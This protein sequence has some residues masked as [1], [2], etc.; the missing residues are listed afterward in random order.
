MK[1]ENCGY[2]IEEDA[3][4]CS[5]CGTKVKMEEKSELK[6]ISCV[7]CGEM[8]EI[9]RHGRKFKDQGLQQYFNSQAWYEG[10]IEPDAFNESQL[11]IYEKANLEL[12][13]SIEYMY[14]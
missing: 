11:N 1:C 4:F 7:C 2:M 5:E 10:T 14:D 12:I 13:Q 8:I 9:A 6:Q 3:L